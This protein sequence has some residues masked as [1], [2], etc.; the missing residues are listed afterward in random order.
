MYSHF[1]VSVQKYYSDIVWMHQ[2]YP[3]NDKDRT[4]VTFN[5]P[6][7]QHCT[8]RVTTN[9]V[10]MTQLVTSLPVA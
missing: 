3:L 1:L 5:T 10:N 8:T 2:A 4:D 7:A 9:L 6:R